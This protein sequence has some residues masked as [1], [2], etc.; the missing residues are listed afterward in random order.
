MIGY[1]Y[2]ITVFSLVL[3]SRFCLGGKKLIQ[4]IILSALVATVLTIIIG[5][6]LSFTTIPEVKEETKFYPAT[7]DTSSGGLKVESVKYT[8]EDSLVVLDT[9]TGITEKITRK[10][11]PGIGGLWMIGGFTETVSIKYHMTDEVYRSWKAGRK[12]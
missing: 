12:K 4:R 1:I 11:V 6:V 5:S 8:P 10:T 2:F 3:L 7:L 9:I